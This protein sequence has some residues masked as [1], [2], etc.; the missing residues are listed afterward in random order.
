L[1]GSRIWR[2]HFRAFRWLGWLAPRAGASHRGA[3][4]SGQRG[5]LVRLPMTA[6]VVGVTGSTTSSDSNI[7]ALGPG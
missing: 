6:G 3:V 1:P 4:V 5:R 2:T 7:P